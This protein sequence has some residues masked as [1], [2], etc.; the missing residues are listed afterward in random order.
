[1]STVSYHTDIIEGAARQLGD[2]SARGIKDASV[3][4][5]LIETIEKAKRELFVLSPLGVLDRL[6]AY[7]INDYHG[8]E[9]SRQELLGIIKEP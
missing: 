4:G 1:M 8:P 7:L 5:G 3:E 2:I 9:K 6:E